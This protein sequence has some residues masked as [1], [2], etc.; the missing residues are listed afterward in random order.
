MARRSIKKLGLR[1]YLDGTASLHND[2]GYK[3]FVAQLGDGVSVAE[4]AVLFKV[5]RMTIYKWLAEYEA[6]R[7]V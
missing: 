1:R 4:L 5:S 6:G 3:E 7:R 2:L